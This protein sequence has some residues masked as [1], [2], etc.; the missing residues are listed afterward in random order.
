[1]GERG[2]REQRELPDPAIATR[3]R[4]SEQSK[5]R[6]DGISIPGTDSSSHLCADLFGLFVYRLCVDLFGL[7]A[8]YLYNPP[9]LLFPQVISLFVVPKLCQK[10]HESM[11][12]CHFRSLPRIQI[13]P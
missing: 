5:R 12:F 11:V 13:S 8:W 10:C 7:L 2:V 1:M 3:E 9:E 4:R 6:V